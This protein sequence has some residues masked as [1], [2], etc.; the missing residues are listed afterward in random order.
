M[1]IKFEKVRYK[2]FLSTGNIFTEIEIDKAHK[3]LIYGGNGSG[4][5]TFID[6]IYFALFGKSYRKVNKD[7]IVNYINKKQCVVE[8]EFSIR[9]DQYKVVRGIKPNI[10]EIYRNGDLVNEEA[11]AA[12]YQKYLEKFILHMNE[13][14]FTQTVILGSTNYIPFMLLNAKDRRTVVEG[15]LDIQLFSVM[16]ELAK[17]K[18][19]ELTRYETNTKYEIEK[20]DIS[21]NHIKNHIEKSNKDSSEIITGIQKNI[22]A[23]DKDNITLTAES[24]DLAEVIK[25]KTEERDAI[26]DTTEINKQINEIRSFAT[27]FDTT[28]KSNLKKA[29][30]YKENDN[31]PSCSQSIS[32]MLRGEKVARLEEEIDT[33]GANYKLAIDKISEY[34]TLID[35]ISTIDR[36]IRALNLE[37]TQK[38]AKIA[39]NQNTVAGYKNNIEQINKTVDISKDQAKLITLQDDRNVLQNDLSS[40]ELEIFDYKS[41]LALLKDNGIKS[42]IVKMYIPVINNLIK[43]YLE[44][45]EFPIIF[46]FDEEFNEFIKVR[47]R[48]IL[49]YPNL[50]EGEKMR[51]NLAL[52]FAFRELAVVRN[53]TH[54]NLIVFDE[55]ADSSLDSTGWDSFLRILHDV[56]KEDQS[57]FVISHKGEDL[58]PKFDDH[59]KFEKKGGQFSEIVDKQV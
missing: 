39:Q 11:T 21:I 28:I 10:F 22:N 51:V 1:L 25:S 46:K 5:T 15:L 3:T 47:G 42:R 20:A 50:S 18:H 45:L 30:F 38:Q 48:D 41:V 19:T 9:S 6:A 24:A 26:G 32:K 27:R 53:A 59:I 2:N 43:K 57:V 33:N 17:I 58:M 23:L 52:I 44:I 55:V 29:K 12:E 7:S 14:L 34:T 4:K 13:K 36:D 8:L 56:A 31:C 37:L 16:N 54:S 49:I 35:Q 40:C